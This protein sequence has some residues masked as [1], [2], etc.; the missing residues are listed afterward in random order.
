MTTDRVVLR[1][2][3]LRALAQGPAT[4][5]EL[6]QRAGGD[7]DPVAAGLVLSTLEEEGLVRRARLPGA[8]WGTYEAR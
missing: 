7:M 4:W 6:Q 3:L 8:L 2:T 5:P 1:D